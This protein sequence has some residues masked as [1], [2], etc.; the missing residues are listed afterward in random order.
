MDSS[1]GSVRRLWRRSL[2][3]STVPLGQYYGS[4][5]LV[6]GPRTLIRS[7]NTDSISILPILSP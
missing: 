1:E 6:T 2:T 3:V 7:V 4:W 5:F